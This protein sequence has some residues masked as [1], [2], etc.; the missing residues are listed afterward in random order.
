M[1]RGNYNEPFFWHRIVNV[2]WA[3]GWGVLTVDYPE[4]QNI[5]LN[6]HS[7]WAFL[8]EHGI[9]VVEGEV[10]DFTLLDPAPAAIYEATFDHVIDLG[11]LYDVFIQAFSYVTV[12]SNTVIEGSDVTA[13]KA[14]VT[15][16]FPGVSFFGPCNGSNIGPTP[17]YNLPLNTVDGAEIIPTCGFTPF[18]PGFDN[19]IAYFVNP[20]DHEATRSATRKVWLI[21]FSRWKTGETVEIVNDSTAPD[22][23]LPVYNTVVTLKIYQKSA[24]LVGAANSITGTPEPSLTQIKSI[25][26]FSASL[27]FINSNGLVTN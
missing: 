23:N 10:I 27:G 22:D 24:V 15:A 25:S 26:Y 8:A 1:A 19:Y 9:A 5:S 20:A 16:T 4:G 12:A 13:W 6:S 7:D 3:G 18:T 2:G 14:G 11:V 21:D 17:P